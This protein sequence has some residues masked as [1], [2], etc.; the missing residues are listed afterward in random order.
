IKYRLWIFNR[1]GEVMFETNNP[2]ATWDGTYKGQA[3]PEGVYAVL[4]DYTFDKLPTKPN[5]RGT[6]T[7]MR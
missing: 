5:Y 2:T 1:W 6:L 3:V 7:I 4:I